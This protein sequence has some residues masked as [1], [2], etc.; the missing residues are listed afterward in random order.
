MGF[1]LSGG[2]VSVVTAPADDRFR[3]AYVP[4]VTP[5][6]WVRIWSERRPELPLELVACA[7]TVEALALLER[8]AAQAALVRPP[9]TGAPQSISLYAETTVAVVPKDHVVTAFAEVAS[10]DLADEPLLL[11]VSDPLTW[12]DRPGTPVT[13]RPATV[14][15]AIELVATGMGMLLVPQSVARLHHRRDLT[16]RPVAGA[17]ATAVALVWP[18]GETSDRVDAFI[19]I[20]RGRSANSSR[21][22]DEPAPKRSA[23][24][25]TLA[26]QAARAAAGKKS[27]AGR[28]PGRSGR[29]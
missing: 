4:G 14:S 11:P 5:A 20:V 13:H 9:L 3:L 21:G 8:G 12:P 25:K 16:Y 7:G 6:K 1:R 15:E 2:T 23:R 10:A 24:E 27:S 17:P 22:N 28:K 29:R 26:K 19:G 18:R